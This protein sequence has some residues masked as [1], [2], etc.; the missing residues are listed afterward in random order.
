[1]KAFKILAVSIISVLI[2]LY[3]V[4]LF[5]LP[6]YINLNKYNPKI[7]EA[8]QKSTG[9]KVSINDLKLNTAWDLSAG[10]SIAKT[11]LNY[12]ND[13][14]FAQINNLQVRLSLIPLIYKQIRIEKISADKI[15][16]NVDL[17]KNDKPLLEG[18]FKQNKNTNLPNNFKYSANMPNIHIKKYR[19]SFI[20]ANKINNYTTKGSSL[21]I[22]DFILNKKIRLTANGELILNNKKQI[23]YK[24]KLTSKNTDNKKPI[25]IEFMKVFRDLEKY[26]IQSNIETDINIANENIIGKMFIDKLTCSINGFTY[27]P[28]SLKL[29]FLG[30]KTK[31]NASLHTSKYSKAIVT[32]LLKFSGKKQIDLHVK[33]GNTDIKDLLA[34]SKAIYKSIG[35]NKLQNI[36]A[37]GILKADFDIKSDFKKIESSGY[38][39]IKNANVTDKLY[40]VLVSSINADIDFSKNS[41]Y[42]NKATANV[43]QQPVKITGTINQNA[44]ANI[45]VKA[46]QLPIK[47]VLLAIGQKKLLNENQISSGL[48]D[49][50]VSLIGRLDKATPQTTVKVNNLS[51]KNNK[52]HYITKIKEIVIIIGKNK[53]GS[54]KI[55]GTLIIANYNNTLKL[56]I[57]SIIFDK[58]SAKIPSTSLYINNL[59]TLLNGTISLNKSNTKIQ[60]ITIKIPNQVSIPLQGY[61]SSKAT[62]L[63]EI[64]LSGDINNPDISGEIKAPLVKMPSILTTLQNV[65]IKLGQDII[66]NCPSIKT[67]DSSF[68]LNAQIQ[69]NNISDGIVVKYVT[70]NS[71]MLNLNTII[72]ALKTLSSSSKSE[73]IIKNGKSKIQNFKVGRIS[74]DN[75]SSNLSL[76]NNILYIEN[77]LCN[78]YLGKVAGDISYSINTRKTALNLQ[79]REL[80]A[81][82]AL[83]A[84][85]GRND[86]IKG[87]LDFDSNVSFI[88]YA[89]NEIQKSLNGNINF[90]ISN[91]QMGVLGKLEHLLYAQNVISNSIFKA[92]LNTTAKALTRKN[93]GVYKY[94]KGKL[95]FSNGWANINWIKT[96]GPS[97][98]LYMTG[99]YYI[100]E[101]SASL[102]ILGRISDDVVKILGPIGEFS[103]DKVITSIP[104]LGEITTFFANQFA[105]NPTYENTSQIPYLTPRT[106]FPTREFKVIIDG[107]LQKQSSVKSFKWIARPRVQNSPQIVPE[108]NEETKTQTIPDFVNNL[109]NFKN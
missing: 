75:I 94:M 74:A 63:G 7:A 84:L 45:A 2:S 14:K 69:K 71:E 93:T 48:A 53:Q 58:T 85:T 68:N 72:P 61:P 28:S 70:L 80:S 67:A 78:A 12:P 57:F 59:K 32:G 83:I 109:P 66:L 104:K 4:F 95:I 46:T 16:M 106:E 52:N 99:R 62:I 42:F 30:D 29:T 65:D 73:I 54:A 107:D 40:K 18:I 56:P 43:N 91:G 88:G 37:N 105:T 22:T 101:N 23:T 24:V 27:P 34:I 25:N 11:D 49:I 55:K 15:M 21:N 19:I 103:M 38:L 3:L 41:I 10:T 60:A 77:L 81:N 100:P 76:K 90:I 17:D 26:N 89:K 51:I 97:M 92:N 50:N 13:T 35:Q 108:T 98:S 102:I 39:K 1:M 47:S 79:G 44:F 64:K 82:P 8:I 87:I 33:S 20:D 36:D 86:N 9:L 5:V 31:I 96:S 6:H